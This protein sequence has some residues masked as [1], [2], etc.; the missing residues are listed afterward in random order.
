M[1]S[2]HALFISVAS[3][4]EIDQKSAYALLMSMKTITFEAPEES[5]AAIDE[6]AVNLEVDRETVLREALAQHIA[7]YE[8][9]VADAAEADRQFDEGETIAH[10]DVLAWL[11]AQHPLAKK[12]EAA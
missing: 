5:I 6:I 1:P 7:N 2:W 9:D 3:T 4:L 8:Q 11:E 12:S 10:E